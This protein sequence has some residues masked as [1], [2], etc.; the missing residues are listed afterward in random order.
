M[1]EL[2]ERRRKKRKMNNITIQTLGGETHTQQRPHSDDNAERQEQNH[3]H[4]YNI[5]HTRLSF[6]FPRE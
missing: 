5:Y 2:Y 3:I 1:N 4:A 6:T